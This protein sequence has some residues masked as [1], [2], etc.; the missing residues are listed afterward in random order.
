[1]KVRIVWKRGDLFAPAPVPSP[2]ACPQA[3]VDI[4]SHILWE[5]DDG[6][7]GLEETMAMLQ[8]AADHGTTDIVATPHANF[9][10]PYDPEVIAERLEILRARP[11]L[12]VRIHQGCD[13]HMSIGNIWDALDSPQKYTINGLNYLLVEFADVLIPPTTEEVL[14]QFI[15]R[16][17]VPIVTHPERNRILQ[18]SPERLQEWVNM[19]CLVQ[20]TANSLTGGFGKVARRSAWNLLRSNLAHV[21]ASD[22]HDTV[23]RTTNLR[24]AWAVL[25]Q[26]LGETAARRLLIDHP[27][28]IVQ[29]RKP[30]RA[31]TLPPVVNQ[32]AEAA[33]K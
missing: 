30:A 9:E 14:G 12:P 10:Y 17:I 2:E 29:G 5:M 27:A 18:N 8:M 13:F 15:E 24:D 25:K 19:G 22:A 6:S 1:M 33:R 16:S 3:F 11:D 28:A 4:H 26:E 21:V 31:A 23:Y 20:L 32:V 7:H